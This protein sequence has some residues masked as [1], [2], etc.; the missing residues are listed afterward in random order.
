MLHYP[1][2]DGPN[3]SDL[4]NLAN[5]QRVCSLWMKTMVW[6]RRKRK[7]KRSMERPY[8]GHVERT[9]LQM[10]SGFVATFVRSGFMESV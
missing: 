6:M 3:Y 8:V 10:S 2:F 9:M 4:L 7:K 1:L 5:I